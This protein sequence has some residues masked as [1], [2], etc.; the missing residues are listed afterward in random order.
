MSGGIHLHRWGHPRYI[1]RGKANYGLKIEVVLKT[2]ENVL[3]KIESINQHL[4][5]KV[6][7]HDKPETKSYGR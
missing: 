2:Y 3:K 1:P 5:H 4:C 7:I 6:V